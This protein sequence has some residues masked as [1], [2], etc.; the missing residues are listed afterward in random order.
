MRTI[1]AGMMAVGLLV[2]QACASEQH[3]IKDSGSTASK[4]KEEMEWDLFVDKLKGDKKL[5]VARNM[6]LTDAEAEK[7]WPLYDAYQDDLMLINQRLDRTIADFVQSSSQGPLPDAKASKL[8]EE[9]LAVEESEV[10]LKQGYAGQLYQVLP[11]TKAARYIQLE[12][13]IR[14]FL[15][16]EMSKLIPLAY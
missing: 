15:K 13:K 12:N 2:L 9:M 16:F 4:T 14:A 11:A 6:D 8:L 5:L 7:F 3:S 1:L 10:A